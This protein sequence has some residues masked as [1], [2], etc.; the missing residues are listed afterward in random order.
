M[1]GEACSGARMPVHTI[2][3]IAGRAPAASEASAR[4][5]APRRNRSVGERQVGGRLA[6]V[7]A[8]LEVEGD[9]L[10]VVEMA[11]AA[12][13]KRGDVDEDVLGATLGLDEAE[14]L[15]GVEPFHGALGHR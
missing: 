5:Q 15:G 12:A 6:A 11:D 7:A 4:R 1:S 14:A 2:W 13:L 8:A 3:A 10:A 9:L